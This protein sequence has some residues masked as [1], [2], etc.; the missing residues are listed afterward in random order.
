MLKY[1]IIILSNHF[2]DRNIDL[3]CKHVKKC[4]GIADADCVFVKL[5]LPDGGGQ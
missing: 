4:V 3:S 1:T 2:D 5:N